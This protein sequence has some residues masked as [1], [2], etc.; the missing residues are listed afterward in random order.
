MNLCLHCSRPLLPT[1]PLFCTACCDS[2]NQPCR[3]HIT[4]P[5]H[6]AHSP[7]FPIGAY[8]LSKTA[9]LG[10]TKGL[11]Q[12]LGPQGITVNCVAPG[13]VP[14][15]FSSALLEDKEGVSGCFLVVT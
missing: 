8:G 14:T 2:R 1:T 7:P 12:E 9:L 4:P 3:P 10:L 11:S 15:K 6:T 5:A 13:F